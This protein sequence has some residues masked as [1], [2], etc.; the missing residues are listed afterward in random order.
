MPCSIHT[1]PNEVTR[2]Q[3]NIRHHLAFTHF[4]SHHAIDSYSNPRSFSHSLPPPPRTHIHS[5]LLPDSPHPPLP[6]PPCCIA[7]LLQTHP[8]S[9]PPYSQVQRALPL[10]HLPQHTR[11]L[12]NSRR[13]RY[14]VRE[15][16]REPKIRKAK[17]C[18]LTLPARKTRRRGQRAQAPNSSG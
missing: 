14:F 17:P 13:R 5:F 6:T 1:L 4:I 3:F 18:V 8:R 9:L 11:P 10:L 2:P 16:E 12:L 15:F 7:G